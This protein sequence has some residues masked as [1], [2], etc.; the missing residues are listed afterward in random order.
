MNF[1][2]SLV[3]TAGLSVSV[4]S[5]PSLASASVS[6]PLPK[7]SA[8]E[9]YLFGRSL[10][11]FIALADSDKHDKRLDWTSDGCSIP[12]LTSA[13]KN[14]DFTDSC[15]RHDF[16]YRN[17][18]YIDGGKKWTPTMRSRVDTQFRRDMRTSCMSRPLL[19]R[20]SCLSW[21]EV[22]YRAVRAT[23]GR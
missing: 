7:Q 19:K 6:R 18:P 1:I 2:G 9:L 8:A 17:L 16:G 14:Y 22:F 11:E 10:P 12:I 15:R 3:V 21:S 23:S 4:L 13:G 5:A 20:V